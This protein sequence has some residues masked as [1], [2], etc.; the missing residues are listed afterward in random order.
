[1][2]T[3]EPFSAIKALPDLIWNSLIVNLI[4]EI[5]E[6]SLS[7]FRRAKE[8]CKHA[9]PTTVVVVVRLDAF[10]FSSLD[11]L[12]IGLLP[13]LQ[14]ILY[15]VWITT[16]RQL[17]IVFVILKLDR[18]ESL[19]VIFACAYMKI[20]ENFQYKIYISFTYVYKLKNIQILILK[21]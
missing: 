9:L 5:L 21:F 1:M 3:I 13:S 14:I 2:K 6:S 8:C 16:Q 11:V 19:R 17:V 7:L 4:D 18:M 20:V 10:H 12:D 15:K